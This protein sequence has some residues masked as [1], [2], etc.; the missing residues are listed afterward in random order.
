MV[1]GTARSSRRTR[2]RPSARRDPNDATAPLLQEAPILAGVVHCTRK[3]AP[4]AHHGNWFGITF[5]SDLEARTQL[6]YLVQRLG[7]DSG[8]PAVQ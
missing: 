2:R 8:G 3:S 6:I 5:F 4:H 1:P 7:D